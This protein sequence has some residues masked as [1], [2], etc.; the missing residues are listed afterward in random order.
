VGFG[1]FCAYLFYA[2]LIYFG[3]LSDHARDFTTYKH[4]AVE[5]QVLA[6]HA[7]ELSADERYYLVSKVQESNSEILKVKALSP[8]NPWRDY[9][10][11]NYLTCEPFDI[12]L[13]DPNRRARKT[14]A[15]R[16]AV[17]GE[18]TEHF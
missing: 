17:K 2:T 4:H 18:L 1:V 10:N 14:P 3:N 8:Y 6:N 16:L 11:L 9:Y 12:G 15:F 5:W 13:F 7:E